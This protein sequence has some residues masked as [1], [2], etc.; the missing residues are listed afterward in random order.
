MTIPHMMTV[1]GKYYDINIIFV[2][3]KEK[4]YYKLY[5]SA[6]MLHIYIITYSVFN[7]YSVDFDSTTTKIKNIVEKYIPSVT[8]L[9]I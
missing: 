4:K 9:G 1:I 5:A 3:E 2:D 6:S 7:K 8:L